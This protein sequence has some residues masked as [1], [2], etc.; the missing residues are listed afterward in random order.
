MAYGMWEKEK[1]KD[2]NLHPHSNQNPG[3]YPPGFWFYAHLN[4]K[5]IDKGACF[6][7]A[8]SGTTC[9]SAS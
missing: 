2:F 4:G 1:S 8:C 7:D 6:A 3:A 9:R 5:S